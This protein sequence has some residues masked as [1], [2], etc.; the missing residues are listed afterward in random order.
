M[1]LMSNK[2]Q[3][4][5]IYTIVIYA[6]LF[7]GLPV[8][9][10]EYVQNSNGQ[11]IEATEPPIRMYASTT[12]LSVGSPFQLTIVATKSEDEFLVF[13][14]S[15]QFPNTFTLLG[16]KIDVSASNDSIR[17][18]LQYYGIQDVTLSNLTLRTV[19]NDDTIT[20]LL[21]PISFTFS[22]VLADHES[23]I[24]SLEW[25]PLKEIYGFSNPWMYVILA[26]SLLALIYAYRRYWKEKSNPKPEIT[27][28][29]IPQYYSPLEQLRTLLDHINRQAKPDNKED[30]KQYVSAISDAI[31]GYYEDLY[32]FP[33]LES[34]SREL[35]DYLQR[36]GESLRLTELVHVILSEADRVKF[37]KYVPSNEALDTMLNNAFLFLDEAKRKHE[38][39]LQSHEED[40]Y[41]THGKNQESSI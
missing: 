7:W 19:I 34:T 35:M 37:A 6:F 32:P 16:S 12:E 1:G 17:Y 18:T 31:R 29:E 28:I 27:P 9:G 22:S 24:D 33:A 38:R 30:I 41:H 36:I 14:D 40:F 2:H 5:S 3:K 23:I 10:A 11:L 39:R 26:L 25:K 15:T 20:S 8:S 21:P 13:P 4:Y